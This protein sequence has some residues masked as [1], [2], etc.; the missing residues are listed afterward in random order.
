MLARLF[1]ATIALCVSLPLTAQ[2]PPSVFL[3]EL[4]WTEIRDAMQAGMTTV[5]IPTAGTE[6]NGPHMVLGKHKY[7]V[8][9]S[10]ERIARE[11]GDALIAPVVTYVPEGNIDPPSGHM[12]YPGTITLPNEVFMQLIEYATRSLAAHGFTDV[13][14]IGDSGGNQRGM[15]AVAEKLNAEWA[16]GTTR[17]HF[18]GDYYTREA[19][20]FEAWLMEQGYTREEIG[21]HAGIMDTSLLLYVASQYIRTDRL[22]PNGGFDGSGVRGD[23]SKASVEYG[24]MGMQLQVNAALK[25]I[26]RL[27]G[28]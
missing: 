8:N 1:P 24:R 15:Q 25:Q 26:R 23:P 2:Q 17:V 14:L 13:L 19:T 18:I 6:Q 7:I 11:L 9:Y 28:H 21:S 12:R 3:E 22:A 27:R 16:G 20:G 5:I 4:T 10:S